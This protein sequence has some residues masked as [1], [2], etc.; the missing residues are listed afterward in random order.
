MYTTSKPACATRRAESASYAPGAT[1]GSGP[2][3][4]SR[5]RS[6][7]AVA[8]IRVERQRAGAHRVADLVLGRDLRLG[9]GQ[10]VLDAVPRDGDEPVAV[11]GDPVAGPDAHAADDDRHVAVVEQLPAWD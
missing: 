6:E 2:A 10:D 7:R 1:T 9:L 11:A 4:R 8:L 3:S 5:S